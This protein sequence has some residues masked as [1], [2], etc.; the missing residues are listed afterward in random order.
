MLLWEV[1]T[2]QKCANY[3]DILNRLSK[4]YDKE[5]TGLYCDD[6]LAVFSNISGPQADRIKRHQKNFRRARPENK[7]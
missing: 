4:K 5:S 7:D 1:M 6:G 3:L 2:E